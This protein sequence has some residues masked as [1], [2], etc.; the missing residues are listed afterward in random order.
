MIART[1]IPVAGKNRGTSPG[2]NQASKDGDHAEHVDFGSL[3]LKFHLNYNGQPIL[4]VKRNLRLSS[5]ETPVVSN[6]TW[7]IW[8]E[9]IL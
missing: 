5:C 3:N 8:I 2:E 7:F 9:L 4:T 6:L 1:A